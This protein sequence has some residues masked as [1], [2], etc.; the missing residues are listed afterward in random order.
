MEPKE[1]FKEYVNG[2]LTIVWKPAKCIHA[3]VCV[4]TLPQVYD[5]NGKPWIKADNASIDALKAQIGKCPSGALSYRMAGESDNSIDAVS[6]ATEVE[7]IKNGPMIVKGTVSIALPDGNK[8]EKERS[9]AFCRCGASADKPF[10]D[11][12]HKKVGFEG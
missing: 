4:D 12:T 1:K 5:P 8:M 3:A 2:D 9:T 6:D 10:C 7:V 11:G